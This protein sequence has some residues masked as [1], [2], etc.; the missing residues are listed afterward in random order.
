M[1]DKGKGCFARADITSGTVVI[2]EQP[3]L[4]SDGSEKDI[5]LQFRKLEKAKREAYLQLYAKTDVNPM[6]QDASSKLDYK[7][8]QI[9]DA[10]N[11]PEGEVF[12]I[13]SRIN[14]SCKPNLVF[15]QDDLCFYATDN[16]KR[17]EELTITYIDPKLGKK[18]RASL[19]GE[20]GITCM[21]CACKDIPE[22]EEKEAEE[23]NMHALLVTI[24]SELDI[25]HQSNSDP[26]DRYDLYEK[27]AELLEA[28]GLPDLD[29]SQWSVPKS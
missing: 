5:L 10:N 11:F 3:L 17:G 19:L 29:L 24:D 23:K 7:V 1:P 26:R 18:E 9:F 12:E 27:K 16:I 13:A 14:H 22:A 25:L 4:V 15:H 8:I 6:A 21:C 28:L 20:L 2:R